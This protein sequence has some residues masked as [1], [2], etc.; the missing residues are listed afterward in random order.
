MLV[1]SNVDSVE[2]RGAELSGEWHGPLVHVRASYSVH[3]AHDETTEQRLTNAPQRL[4]KLVLSAPLGAT[5]VRAGLDTQYVSRRRTLAG[6]VGGYTVANLTFTRS[7]LA[8][9]VELSFSLYNL[10]DKAYGD[11]GSVEH[12]QDVIAQDGRTVRLKLTYR[13]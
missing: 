1:F 10:F 9:G 4:A 11:P 7:G 6:E 2:A 3:D 13:F 5:G 12:R 8:K